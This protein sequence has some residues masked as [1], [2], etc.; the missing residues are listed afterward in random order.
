[1]GDNNMREEKSNDMLE[2]FGEY[3]D[4][5]LEVAPVYFLVN[6]PEGS[7]DWELKCNLEG[8]GPTVH[9]YI[10]LKALPLVFKQFK[11]ILA[12]ELTENFVDETLEMV[13][14]EIM[15]TVRAEAQ[16]A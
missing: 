10:L 11:D 9:F 4:K 5:L 16:D 1:M 3:M 6:S 2:K 8:L 15:E 14:E 12:D 7:K 13:K